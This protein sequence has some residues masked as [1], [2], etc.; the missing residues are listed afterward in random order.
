MPHD[1]TVDISVRYWSDGTTLFDASVS[2]DES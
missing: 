1:G 2:L